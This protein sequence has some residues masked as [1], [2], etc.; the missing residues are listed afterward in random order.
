MSE[1]LRFITTAR[2]AETLGVSE[3][4][5]RA[6]CRHGLIPATRPPGTRKWLITEDGFLSWL[7]SGAG[8]RA[9]SFLDPAHRSSATETE[10]LADAEEALRPRSPRRSPKRTAAPNTPARRTA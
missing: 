10:L 6:W 9:T 4:S 3:Q 8:Q 1:D 7:Q 5:V 2:V